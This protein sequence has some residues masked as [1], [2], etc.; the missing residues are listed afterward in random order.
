LAVFVIVIFFVTSI[1]S[2]ALVMDSFATGEENKSPVYYRIGW[3]VAVGAV[4]AALL[5]INDTGIEA[6][7]EVVII[8]ALPFLLMIVCLSDSL[9]KGMGYYYA[10]QRR[11]ATRQC[12][13]TDSPEKREEHE[14][15]PAPGYDADGNELGVPEFAY[16]EEGRFHIPGHVVVDGDVYLG[17]DVDNDYEPENPPEVPRPN[18]V[19]F[20]EV[21][22]P[23]ESDKDDKS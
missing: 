13:K 10:A 2:A 21:T 7:Q 3:A 23:E 6:I 5:F 15:R 9:L 17:G 14:S 4:T 8:V 18:K 11:I 1:D 12:E 22:D 20:V 16:D 19:K